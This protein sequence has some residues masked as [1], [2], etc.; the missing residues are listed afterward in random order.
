M[1]NKTFVFATVISIAFLSSTAPGQLKG[2]SETVSDLEVQTG[3]AR[4]YATQ[5]DRLNDSYNLYL[6][7]LQQPPLD[8]A[9][10]EE[11]AGLCLKI[12][13]PDEAIRLLDAF[14]ATLPPDEA[15]K[16]IF[17]RLNLQKTNYDS[18]SALQTLIATDPA[19]LPTEQQLELGRQ[20]ELYGAFYRAERIYRQLPT[21]EGELPLIQ[22]LISTGRFEQ[23]DWML[24]SNSNP[25]E[26]WQLVQLNSLIKQK[27]LPE[28]LQL[29]D[30]LQQQYPALKEIAPL[31]AEILFGLADFEMAALQ[32]QTL[33]STD[34]LVSSLGRI[35]CAHWLDHH[36][37]ANDLLDSALV[38]F[39]TA[40]PLQFER[41]RLNNQTRATEPVDALLETQSSPEDLIQWAYLYSS[42]GAYQNAVRCAD[43]AAEF[44]PSFWDAR[45]VQAE[46]NGIAGNWN[47]AIELVDELLL[48]AP[49]N[50]RLQLSRARFLAWSKRYDEALPAYTALHELNKS[51]PLPVRERARTCFWAKQRD[52]GE[53]TFEMLLSP[54]VDQQLLTALEPYT[55]QW[56]EEIEQLR[57]SVEDET[58]WQGYETFTQNRAEN[59]SAIQTILHN[60]EP[61]YLI[62][63]G[64]DL[65]HQTFVL[66][67]NRRFAQGLYANQ[68]LAELYPS[69]PEVLFNLAQMQCTLRLC[70]DVQETY[71]KLLRYYPQHTLAALALEKAQIYSNPAVRF[72]YDH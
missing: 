68:E 8:P 12:N 53:A 14:T 51:D 66:S 44:Y 24:N 46:I 39:P 19:N 62:Q 52:E 61:T 11:F 29:S 9:L 17:A 49:D 33:E 35:R 38:Q 43:S 63:K 2:L 54:S 18:I 41:I 30:Q 47:R 42:A 70:D 22:L 45:F 28:A 36:T 55:E 21:S 58:I 69:N 15:A 16:W 26:N 40:I 60:L 13:Q 34:P 3:L 5:P 56:P 6:K 20:L 7:L 48:F 37:E 1:K 57:Q 64:A 59:A 25:D 72:D 31:R 67:W 10:L 32:Y 50:Y 71:K 4:L 27:R 65:E 23:A